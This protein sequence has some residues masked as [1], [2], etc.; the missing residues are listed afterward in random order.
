MQPL[1]NS[2]RAHSHAHGASLGPLC[3][4]ISGHVPF[5]SRP[6]FWFQALAFAAAVFGILARCYRAAALGLNGD[7]ALQLLPVHLGSFR[8]AF[9][10]FLQFHHPPLLLIL[11]YA[12]RPLTYEE[13]GARLISV[14]AGSLFPVILYLWLRGR[15]GIVAACTAL[16]LTSLSLNLITLAPQVRSY[17]LAFFFSALTLLWLDRGIDSARLSRVLLAGCALALAIMSDYSVAILCPAITLYGFARLHEARAPRRMWAAWGAMILLAL[18]VFGALYWLQIRHF[19]ENSSDFA[20]SWLRNGFRARGEP[21]PRFL[22][23]ATIKQFAY[24]AGTLAAGVV[25]AAS[26]ALALLHASFASRLLLLTPFAT[27]LA[28]S[29]LRLLPFGSTRHSAVVSIVIAAGAA[30]AAERWLAPRPRWL[31]AVPLAAVLF[32]ATA[33]R[34]FMDRPDSQLDRKAFREAAVFL[35]SLPATTAPILATGEGRLLIQYY[36]IME[37]QPPV[38]VLGDTFGELKRDFFEQ[39]FARFRAGRTIAPGDPVYFVDAGYFPVELPE[40]RP[41]QPIGRFGLLT[42]WRLNAVHPAQR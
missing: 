32:I 25:L 26:F 24:L 15:A 21:L 22:A 35:S 11:T 13:F 3:G 5:P 20:E 17:S 6:K 39:Q 1:E 34:D 37:R 28:L 40:P 41:A 30:L 42:I 36:R 16:L 29:L 14:I 9:A 10:Q 12:I 38:R 8:D 33:R 4:T 18:A 19:Q 27:G 23:A 2:D 7:E 31:L